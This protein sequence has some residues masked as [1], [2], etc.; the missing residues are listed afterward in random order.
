MQGQIQLGRDKPPAGDIRKPALRELA[1]LQLIHH[2]NNISR[3]ELI[4]RTGT[5]AGQ[6][7]A[8]VQRLISKGLVMESGRSSGTAGR[9]AL[10]LTVRRDAGYVVGVD[11]GSFYLRVV[12]TDIVGNLIYKHQAETQLS[13]GRK[14]VLDRTFSA[15]HTAIRDCGLPRQAIRGI[16]MGHSGIIDSE[17]GVVVSF[18]R[19]GQ[20]AEWKNV[21]L[22]EMLKEEF[23]LASLVEDS[24][25][26]IASAEQRFGLGRKAHD[27]VYIDVGMG[28]GAGIILNGKLYRGPGGAAGEFGHMTVEENGPLCCCGNHGCVETVAS[29]TAII[30]AAR[31]AI[32]HGV[33][34]KIRELVNGDLRRIS[35]ELIVE[36]AQQND[37]LA[38]RVLHEAVSHIGIALADVV[39]LLNP[40]LVIFGG[41]LFR[42]AP[43]LLEL[44]KQ[45]IKQRALERSANQVQLRVSTLGS[46]AGALGAASAMSER[47]VE[48]LY[49]QSCPA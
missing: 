33:D 6:V 45:V 24:V 8:V 38:F 10:G 37:S 39:N 35:V 26:A 34:S 2:D 23:G 25:R 18:P 16:G 32:E 30:Q 13:E 20:M 21:P 46:E 27:F 49:R 9:R 29:C 5:S 3:V 40:S 47:V 19:P 48:A 41:P 4:R 17:N 43:P 42:A 15:I 1:I 36:A 22:R 11:L 7:T 31:S 12:I 14:R 44:L 28:I